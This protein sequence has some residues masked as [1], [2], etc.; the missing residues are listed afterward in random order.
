[1]KLS[2]MER[3]T[4]LGLLPKEGNFTTLK[5][6]RELRESLSFDDKENKELDFKFLD[7]GGVSWNDRKAKEKE[8]KFNDTASGIITDALKE[9]DKEKKL[10][11]EHFTIYEK[12]ME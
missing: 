11:D 12:F 10:R 5:I 8:F 2:V 1:M 6:V 4:L 9:L 7:S 3:L